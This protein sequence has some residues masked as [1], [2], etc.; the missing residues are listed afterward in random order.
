MYEPL[1]LSMN[2]PEEKTRH[3]TMLWTK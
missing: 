1:Q 2:I 3:T